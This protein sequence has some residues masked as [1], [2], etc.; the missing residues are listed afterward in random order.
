MDDKRNDRTIWISPM[1][2]SSAVNPNEIMRFFEKAQECGFV[3]DI[4]VRIGPDVPKRPSKNVYA[5]VEY[6]HENS[7]PRSLRVASKKMSSIGGTR[8]RIFRAG[9]KTTIFLR[10]PKKAGGHQPAVA[11]RGGRGGFRGGRR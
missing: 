11:A 10:P 6:A 3:K 9:T 2:L 4:R 7:L 5:F 1:P 8:F